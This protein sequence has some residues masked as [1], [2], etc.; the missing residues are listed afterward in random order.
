MKTI[1]AKQ[2]GQGVTAQDFFVV[3]IGASAGG[4][5]AIKRFLSKLPKDFENPIVFIQHLSPG[6]K[7]HMKDLLVNCTQ[8]NVVEVDKPLKIKKGNFYI[9]MPNTT[10]TIEGNRLVPHQRDH[11]TT[12]NHPINQFFSS[13]A[14]A[15]QDKA[16][17]IILSGT[18]TD[19]ASGL[20][21]IHQ[22]GGMVLIQKPEDAEF[23][24]MPLSAIA[25]NLTKYVMAAENLAVKVSQ[26]TQALGNAPTL[27]QEILEDSEGFEKILLLI[28]LFTNLDFTDY[29]KP[30]LVRRIAKR[31]AQLNFADLG[32]YIAYFERTHSEA[33]WL[34]EDFLIGVTSFFR[35]TEVW[36]LLEEKILPELIASTPRDGM[37]K[38][39]SVGCSTGEEAYSLA[40]QLKKILEGY[41]KSPDFKIFCCDLA[42]K[43][44]KRASKGIFPKG[45]LN[46]IPEKY[47]TFFDP[48]PKDSVTINND[49]RQH[50]IF[51][52]YDYL[53]TS[54]M[55]NMDM[56]LCRNILIYMKPVLQEK[57][58]KMFRFSLRT[59]GILVLGH[60]ESM[61]R[62]NRYFDVIDEGLSFY[63]NIQKTIYVPE[64]YQ[65]KTSKRLLEHVAKSKDVGKSKTL[66]DFLPNLL[67]DSL[68]EE[69]G[70]AAIYINPMGNIIRAAG[71]FRRFLQLPKS[72]FSNNIFDLLPLG[73][74]ATLKSGM[75][76][77]IKAE[78]R[79]R[80]EH[81]NLPNMKD[82]DAVN[83]VCNPYIDTENSPKM[84]LIFLPATQAP[85]QPA[86]K[87]EHVEGLE[88]DAIISKLNE[89]LRMAHLDIASLRNQIDVNTEE[90]Q[91][92][93]EELMATNEELQST[94]EELQSVNEEL[95]AVNSELNQK[96]KDFSQANDDIDNLLNGT[97]IEVILVDKN[98]ILRKTTPF[99][100]KHFNINEDDYGESLRRFE[101]KFQNAADDL[102][103]QCERTIKEGTKH[104][105][106]LQNLKGQWFVQRITPFVNS[107]NEIDGAIVSYVDITEIK[108]LYESNRELERFA[109][110]ASH[111]LQ[112]PLRNIID[113]IELLQSE[114]EKQLDENAL[115]YLRF[116]DEAAYRMGDLIK[117]TLA[118][119]RLGVRGEGVPVDLDVTLKN[120]LKDLD[121]KIKEKDA[122]IMVM[123][124]MP[125][126]TGHSI[127][128]HSLF[129]NLVS[130]ALKFVNEAKKPEVRISSTKKDDLYLFSVTDNGIGIS[131][132]DKEK[133]F[134][135]FK[136]LH[137]TDEYK[138]TGI[139]LAHCKKIVELHGGTIWLESEVK[140]GTTFYFT[141]SA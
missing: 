80:I 65:N 72:G 96:I 64:N 62:N 61:L 124:K 128:F 87:I 35:D 59:G 139:G 123:G 118:Y 30:T 2:Q 119:S 127:E 85:T 103:T 92:S 56:V 22:L 130:N 28:N 23:N 113:F 38:I 86:I 25:N 99:I 26:L 131:E 32:Q 48:G 129:L 141:L 76:A 97:D 19:G 29:K 36:S 31:I 78:K 136:R 45:I 13:L 7:S 74:A 17:G 122:A 11:K 137:N 133:V 53:S 60:S 70:L 51:S 88:T 111:D 54:P 34:S 49:I 14:T 81:I 138:G 63:R 79:T 52:H 18:G 42:E 125:T 47:H 102:I 6:H 101:H 94:N 108:M 107:R 134:Q 90:L 68:I 89:E 115:E 5:K 10:L 104:Q 3:G 106:E 37:I 116:I 82:D 41:D 112:E 93:N 24:G 75:D 98:L 57:M 33:V 132:E 12:I 114:Y 15:F 4:L 77:A 100:H 91:T 110:V 135:I 66:Y 50:L 69:L 95:Y 8:L 105:K 83:I 27:E 39:S 120:V 46:E 55:T 40:L 71:D 9:M 140:K 21:S 121:R 73:F 126:L 117:D 84:L 43:R 1:K 67:N 44:I 20:L 58:T 16:M 109:Y